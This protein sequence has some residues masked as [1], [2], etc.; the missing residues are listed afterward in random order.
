MHGRLSP[1]V[2]YGWISRIFSSFLISLVPRTTLFSAPLIE[3][4]EVQLPS[5]RLWDARTGPG[6]KRTPSMNRPAR[7]VTAADANVLAM[8]LILKAPMFPVA[9]SGPV[10]PIG[11]PST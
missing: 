6:E 1:A 2:Q 3:W 10:D 7:P 9:R 4:H 5:L 8:N 11:L